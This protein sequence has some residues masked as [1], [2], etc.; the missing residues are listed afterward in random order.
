M[1]YGI[2]D[3]VKSV[4]DV[5]PGEIKKLLDEYASEYKMTKEVAA[6][7]TSERGSQD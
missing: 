5:S 7:E 2:G 3:L 6:S 1:D 4:N